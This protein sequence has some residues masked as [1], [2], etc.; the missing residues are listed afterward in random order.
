MNTFIKIWNWYKCTND[1]YILRNQKYDLLKPYFETWNNIFF[2]YN[3]H[4]YLRGQLRTSKTCYRSTINFKKQIIIH[5]Y[6]AAQIFRIFNPLANYCYYKALHVQ[7]LDWLVK[8]CKFVSY[9]WIDFDHH[10]HASLNIF[11]INI[12]YTIYCI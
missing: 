7:F 5:F 9:L 2:A 4:L 6:Q 3:C 1:W 10:F 12:E 8:R 11:S